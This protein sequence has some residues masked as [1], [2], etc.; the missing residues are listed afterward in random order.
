MFTLGL[1]HLRRA[2]A[3]NGDEGSYALAAESYRRVLLATPHDS[4]AKFNYELARRRKA[5]GGGSG[6]P[7]PPQPSPEGEQGQA[8][9]REAGSLDKSQAERLLDNA[10]R[11]ERDTHKKNARKSRGAP[12]RTERD[13]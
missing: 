9:P 3:P 13:W 1:A 8:P 5:G 11:D 4:A 12:P 10:A 7:P 2:R 6:A